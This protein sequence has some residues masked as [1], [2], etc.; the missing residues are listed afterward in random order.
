[1]SRSVYIVDGEAFPRKT[2]K[3]EAKARKSE[4]DVN[5]FRSKAKLKKQIEDE[6]L[7][8]ELENSIEYDYLFELEEY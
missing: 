5:E 6:L 3:K 8:K 2:D 1:M 4:F 7:Q